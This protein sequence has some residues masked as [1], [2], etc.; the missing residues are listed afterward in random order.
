MQKRIDQ[1]YRWR[2]PTIID[3][4]PELIAFLKT[5]PKYDDARCYRKAMLLRR[6]RMIEIEKNRGATPRPEMDLDALPEYRHLELV[7]G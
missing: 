2:N 6:E 7:K 3:R 4:D 1:T 5:T